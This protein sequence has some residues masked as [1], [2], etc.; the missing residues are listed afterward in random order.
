MKENSRIRIYDCLYGLIL[1][2]L[3]LGCK[4]EIDF[5]YNEIAPVVLIE[6]RV[7]NE[8]MAVLIT[9]SRSM[10]DS[11]KSKCL[12]GA[13]VLVSW[14]DGSERLVY[15]AVSNQYR[16]SAKG[17]AGK[18]YRLSIDFE[19]QHYEATSQM[20]LPAPIRSAEFLWQPVLKER[21]LAYEVWA[22]DPYPEERNYYWYRM[23]RLSS[24]PH[25][26]K[27][28]K[29]EAYRWSVFDDRGCPPG[30]LYRDV[31]CMSERAAEEDEEENWKSIL[32]DG[33][34]ITFQLMTIDYPVYDY[35][36]SLRAGQSGGANPRSNIVGGCQ[37]YFVAGSITHA[38]TIV[39]YRKDVKADRSGS[40]G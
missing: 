38:D 14:D 12:S 33:D 9:K 4:K 8:G 27:F 32:Y 17:V 25:L 31:M 18:S 23:N 13:E 11:V 10:Q 37:G 39:F 36:A 34:T 24:H 5:D 35:F 28:S 2:F 29:A 19:G 40:G 20:P 16:S 26:A 6:G 7:T 15:D 3:L 21:L 30:L 22:V 1:V